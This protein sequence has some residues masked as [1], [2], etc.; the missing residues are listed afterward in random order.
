MSN[1]YINIERL[2][3]YSLAR[4]L[5]R[6]GWGIY[7]SLAYRDVKVMG[8]QFIRS[9]DSIGANIIE[10]Y[11]RY[12]YL[13][14]VKFYYIARASLQESCGH[15]LELLLERAKI[16]EENYHEI[17]DLSQKLQIKLN[18]F[19]TATKKAKYDK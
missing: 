2:E 9:M 4:E 7:N 13:D 17:K 12:H 16:S 19:I 1:E 3:V 10:G 8:D 18:N 6:V 5:S 14:K 15:W 11:G